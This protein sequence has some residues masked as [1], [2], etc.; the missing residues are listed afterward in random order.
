MISGYRKNISRS[1]VH[2][3]IYYASLC[4][5][6]VALPSS[7]Y[8]ITIA[9]L[10]LTLNW[11]AEAGFRNKFRLFFADKPAFA[12]SLVYAISLTGLLWSLDLNIAFRYDLL[13]KLPTLLL[14]L[15]IASSPRVDRKKSIMLLVLFLVSLFTVTLIGVTYRLFNIHSSFREGSPFMP[16]IYFGI[17]LV[18]GSLQLP[19]LLRKL[20]AGRLIMLGGCLISAWLVFYLFYIRA[21]SGLASLSVVLVYLV[22]YFI[23]RL[24]SLWLRWLAVMVFLLALVLTLY[25]LA[26]I[27]RQTHSEVEL[28]LAAL[29][30][31][32]PYGNNYFHDTGRIIRENGH[33]VYIYICDK[34]LAEEWS[35][36]SE[37]DYNG[38]DYRGWELKHTLYR[39]MASKGLRK[40]RD[41]FTKLSDKDIR[42]V[43]KGVVNF[44]NVRR[45][46][47]YKRAY[48][49]MM[50]LYIYRKSSFKSPQWGSF[51]ERIDTWKASLLAFREKPVFGWGT[52]SILEAMD[53]GF[54]KN[55]SSLAGQNRRPHSQYLYILLSQGIVGLILFFALFSYIIIKTRVS[56]YLIFR[57]FLITFVINFLANNSLENQLGQNIFVFFMLFYIYFY[58]GIAGVIKKIGT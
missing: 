14:P 50:G 10:L 27:Y 29:D 13:H 5:L 18:I 40:D 4:L 57:V 24:K 37:L 49:E 42:A 47:I 23:I 28:D 8:F 33:L 9:L 44:R 21:L 53:Y 17:L 51:A 43:E 55:N 48:E 6:V 58:P 56:R 41:G 35:K 39:Y 19:D 15:V 22:Y 1:T 36:R 20:G 45:P 16:G 52:G 26:G 30:N 11:L 34:E 25:P 38:P 3:W 32:S 31:Q 2:F 54:R 46:G 12:F 7:K